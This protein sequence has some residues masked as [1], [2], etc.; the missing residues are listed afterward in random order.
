MQT[1]LVLVMV[2]MPGMLG[3]LLAAPATAQTPDVPRP[4][5]ADASVSMGWLHS[6]VSALSE[7]ED[8][9]ASARVTLTGQ[10]GFYWTEHL[11][12]EFV[13]ER[14]SREQIWTGQ[15][16]FLP[17]GRIA[18][19]STQHDIQDTRVSVGQ[20][21]Q[22]GHNAWAH[23][24]LGAGVS[25]TRR[26]VESEKSPLFVSDRSGQQTLEPGS[27]ATFTDTR[28]NAFAG[29]VLKAYVTPRAFFRTDLQADFRSSI[30]NVIVRAGFGVD[31]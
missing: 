23:V 9:W 30:D 18:W 22:F 29:V 24:S 6:E 31:F 15:N 25:V 28:T 2:A 1:R 8:N 12:T 7:G 20:Y 21:Y 13:A 17:D 10:A 14:S 5:R 19:R 26:D 4:P 3:W 11:K 16:V 27:T